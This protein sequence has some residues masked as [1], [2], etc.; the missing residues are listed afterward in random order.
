MVFVYLWEPTFCT[1]L[2]CI[3]NVALLYC[4]VSP[5]MVEKDRNMQL[6]QIKEQ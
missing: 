5:M 4:F 3:F 1:Y 6:H 2:S